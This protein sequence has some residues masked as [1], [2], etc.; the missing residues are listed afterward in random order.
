MTKQT[1]SLSK[2]DIRVINVVKAVQDIKNIPDA[3]S[4]IIQKYAEVEN[5]S[6]F[7]DK[8]RGGS[9]LLREKS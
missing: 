5:Y 8:K 7:I 1:I 3:V 6:E 4:F 9:K 2:N